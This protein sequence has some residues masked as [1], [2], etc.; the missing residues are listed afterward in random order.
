MLSTLSRPRYLKEADLFAKNARKLLHRK[1]DLLS[2]EQFNGYATQIDEL[3]SFTR[4]GEAADQKRVEDTVERIDRNFGKLQPAHADIGWR[5]N[6]EVLLVAFVLAIGIR[7]YFLQPFK[8]PTGSME[9]TLNGIIAHSV[10]ADQ[11]LPGVVKR[12]FESVLLGRSY[13]D[14]VSA[15]DDRVIDLKTEKYLGF[16]TYTR[17]FCASGRTYLVHAPI[18]TLTHPTES[19][20]FGIYP[21]P[22]SQERR[23][24]PSGLVDHYRAGQPIAHGYVDT[25]DQVFVDK[26]TYNFRYPRRGDVFVFSTRGIAEI[27]MDDPNVKSQFYIKRLAGVPGDQLRIAD[28]HL[29]INGA[30]AQE[31]GFRRVMTLAHGYRGYSNTVGTRLRTAQDTFTVPPDSYFALGDNSFNSRD[32]RAFGTVPAGNVVGRGLLVYWPFTRHWGLIH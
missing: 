19:D 21:N 5:E 27:P 30:G 10:P 24:L 22:F 11:P 17:I 6:C 12:F 29:F 8:I 28:R 14:A 18:E 9:P 7:A 20:G 32:S 4:N 25:G 31:F 2:D 3:E 15:V 26:F 1:R 23:Y 13:V 16:M